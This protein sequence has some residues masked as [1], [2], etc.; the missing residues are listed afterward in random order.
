MEIKG[1]T[2]VVTG[3]SAGIGKATALEFARRGANLVI[4]ARR[5][6][7]LEAVAA[8]CRA[9]G[10]ECTAIVAD[11]TKRTECTSLI[12]RAGRVD[13]L[14]NNAGFA[15]FDAIENAQPAELQSM[16]DT[17]YFGAV[18]CTQAV[19]RSMLERREGTIINVASIAGMMGYAR[20]GGY[21]ATKFALIGFTE[22][23]RDEVVGR[24][25]RV[26]LVCPSTTETD[27]FETAERGKM[28]AA[29]RLILAI[30]PERVATAICNTAED[31]RFRRILP[32]TA[33]MYMRLNA[34]FPRT[35]HFFMRRISALLEK[36]R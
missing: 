35:A 16:M 3:A 10:V 24:G 9:H 29:S 8:E 11:V 6:D 23:L 33:A 26:S 34:L 4:A 7:M 30:K 32:A 25:V 28:P 21:C 12:E 20:M 31:G 18:W 15:V 36:R 2:V 14:V 22:A 17:N 13:I 19:L 27:F 1:K 5:K